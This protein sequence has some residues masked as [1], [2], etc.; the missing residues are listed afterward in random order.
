L[1]NLVRKWFYFSAVILFIA[2]CSSPGLEM[3][4][5][6]PAQADAL[7]IAPGS[8]AAGEYVTLCIS[9]ASF[10]DRGTHFLVEVE[11]ADD[12][13][14]LT[15]PFEHTD[16]QPPEDP[17][18][19]L[20]DGNG[21]TFELVPDLAQP[22]PGD[23]ILD[24][25][26]TEQ[27]FEFPPV[28]SNAGPFTLHIP[29]VVVLAP[30]NSSIQLDLGQQ[31]GPGSSYL[32]DASIELLGQSVLFDHAEIDNQLYLHLYSAPIDLAQGVVVRWLFAGMPEGWSSGTGPGDKYDFGTQRQ[33]LWF[34]MVKADGQFNTG[35]I[36]IPFY[37]AVLY[38]L[39]PFDMILEGP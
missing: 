14:R 20:A 3:L 2:G 34:P 37:S 5:A 23:L 38:L 19:F 11:L 7:P 9:E 13:L 8:C 35:V 22:V 18:V 31:P 6:A 36:S 32:P 27:L 12:R 16:Y 39:G 15:W 28:P 29:S 17:A 30:L 4:S 33:H 24:G 26:R 10:D 1:E 21:T 25:V